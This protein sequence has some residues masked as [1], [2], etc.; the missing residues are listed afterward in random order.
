MSSYFTIKEILIPGHSRPFGSY[1]AP[2]YTL[3]EDEDG[4][5]ILFT[6]DTIPEHVWNRAVAYNVA[7]LVIPRLTGWAHLPSEDAYHTLSISLD[8]SFFAPEPLSFRQY[9]QFRS[10]E[11]TKR[12]ALR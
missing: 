11:L 12:K 1:S 2:L 7:L 4:M 10:D 6:S 8:K 5:V 9:I 3:L